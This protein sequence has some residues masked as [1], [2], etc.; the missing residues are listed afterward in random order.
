MEKILAILATLT[1]E[2]SEQETRDAASAI[3]K[4][5]GDS[6]EEQIVLAAVHNH[7]ARFADNQKIDK[8][9]A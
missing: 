5:K 9:N 7:L 4:I 1:D 2:S 8:Q 6:R 3:I